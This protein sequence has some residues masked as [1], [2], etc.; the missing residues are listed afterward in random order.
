MLPEPRLLLLIMLRTVKFPFLV[1][2]KSEIHGIKLKCVFNLVAVNSAHIHE[3]EDEPI[4]FNILTY[5][6]WCCW[7]VDPLIIKTLKQYNLLDENHPDRELNIVIDYY[8]GQNLQK[9]IRQS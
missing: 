5:V 3:K 8:S 6:Q 9:K 4:F 1:K 2:L 7:N